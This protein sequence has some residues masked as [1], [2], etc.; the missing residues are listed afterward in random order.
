MLLFFSILVVISGI[1]TILS[2]S[3]ERNKYFYFLKPF[4]T[5][6]I[7]IIAVS[8]PAS[9]P[10]AYKLFIVGGLLASLAG[11]I[12][13]M[14]SDRFF[15]P[16]LGSFLVAHVLYIFAFGSG[17]D[18]TMHFWLLVPLVIYGIGFYLVLHRNLDSMR[19]PVIIYML[20][21]LVMVWMA[22]NRVMA[23]QSVGTIMLVCGAVFFLISDSILA[24]NK[25]IGSIRGAQ[26][27]ILGTY[28]LAQWL[29]A[30]SLWL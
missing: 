18:H 30:S 23:F 25:F 29:I 21:I 1:L 4:T 12:F 20:V 22:A 28:Y 2:E 26:L 14:L 17:I 13:L 11:D 19:V 7:I 6:L 24:Y 16:G 10:L 5:V 8:A 9:F 15:I 3:R 27:F